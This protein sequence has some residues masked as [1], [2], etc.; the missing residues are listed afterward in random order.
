MSD[1]PVTSEVAAY[2]RNAAR[3]TAIPVLHRIEKVAHVAS[4]PRLRRRKGR[5][6]LKAVWAVAEQRAAAEGME[7][8]GALLRS[9]GAMAEALEALVAL[10]LPELL[11]KVEADQLR[12]RTAAQHLNAAADAIAS[13]DFG[14][15]GSAV[16]R[17][18]W[19]LG[20]IGGPLVVALNAALGRATVTRP[21]RGLLEENVA[22]RR[23]AKTRLEHAR[24]AGGGPAALLAAARLRELDAV[25]FQLAAEILRGQ[26]PRLAAPSRRRK[27]GGG[28]VRVLGPHECETFADVGGLDDV[29]DQLR[30][31]VGAILELPEEVERYRVVHNGVLFHGPPGTGKNLLSRAL[32]GEYGL[33]Y[34]RFSPAVIASSYIHEA[35]S[36]LRKLFELARESAPCVLFLDEIDTI[37][38]DRGDQPSADHREVVTQLM[39]CLE[40]YRSVPGLVVVAATNDIDRLDPGLREG[41]FDAR[42][43]VPLPDPDARADILR[44]HLERRGTAID[45]D[46]LDLGELSRATAG[47][48][49]AALE[50][51]VSSASQSA[52]RASKPIARSHLLA[53]VRARGGRD[54]LVVEEWVGWD[55]VVLTEE[56]RERLHEMLNAFTH[57]DLAREL[58][59]K[60]P[61]G[62]LLAGPPGTGKTTVAKAIASEVQASFYEQSA[63]DLLS[64]WA[65]ESEQRVAKLFAKAR[66]NRP[67][68]IFVDEIDALLRRRKQNAASTWE[69]RV[70]GQFLRELDGLQGNEQVLL[71]GATSRADIVD[72]AVVGRR[73]VPVELGLPDAVMRLAI[74]RL[75]CKNVKLSSDVNLR[76]LA[77]ATD[78]LS[79]ADLKRIRDAAG[80]KALNRAAKGRAGGERRKA[81]I[82]MA[83]L[84]AALAA[85]RGRASLVQV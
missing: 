2:R 76:T 66:A 61:P 67:S 50:T 11:G 56:T 34:L 37:A 3:V 7:A 30:S 79:G 24:A 64:K 48:S 51:I 47:Y 38:S 52:L 72:E 82:T 17:A 77:G 85:Q 65:G 15:A 23:Q 1:P 13:R 63:A 45:W 60:A 26:L 44:V 21:R 27:V 57:P 20:P 6:E 10:K 36:N 19:E 62:I 83:D 31:S 71:L 4:L 55:D 74:L 14:A 75:L 42:I 81:A 80:M 28:E 73:L 22:E 46:A 8:V 35:A 49:A 16:E 84:R 29:K 59:V 5:D 9:V 54:R 78:G 53:A 32:A 68:I 70:V 25:G 39:I 41:R 33:R 58:G 43:Y 69:E 18:E 40:E 12:V